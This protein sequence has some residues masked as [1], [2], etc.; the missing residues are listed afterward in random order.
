M[1][2]DFD[3]KRYKKQTF[4]CNKNLFQYKIKMQWKLHGLTNKLVAYTRNICQ[5]KLSVL[6]LTHQSLE[7]NYRSDDSF[8]LPLSGKF[9]TGISESMYCSLHWSALTNSLSFRNL[10]L[11]SATS[12]CM[13]ESSS[14]WKVLQQKYH[15]RYPSWSSRMNFLKTF[16]QVFLKFSF[17]PW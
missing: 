3:L 4:D 1:L 10:H 16:F 15:Q 13:R 8:I 11:N 5:S 9:G 2:R 14:R 12:H 6:A 7:Q 17:L